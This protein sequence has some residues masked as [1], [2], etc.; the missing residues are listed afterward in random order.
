MID[1]VALPPLRGA[2][3]VSAAQNA[4]LETYGRL[5]KRA[6]LQQTRDESVF[7]NSSDP[8]IFSSDD[9]P[10][11]DD[12]TQGRRKKRYLGSWFQRS[13]TMADDDT[14]LPPRPKRAFT[15]QNADSGI[16]M[17]SDDL[18]SDGIMQDELPL[19][20]PRAVSSPFAP[21]IVSREDSVADRK[22][23]AC[24]D[25]GVE[26][27]DLSSMGLH[28]IS[29]EA[30]KPLAEFSTT[31]PLVTKGVPF[32][33]KD[34]E[35]E[36]YLSSNS[37]RALPR[38]MFDVSYLTTLSL[39]NNKLREL[40]PAIGQLRSLRDL[41]IAQNSL[42]FLPAELLDLVADIRTTRLLHL[43]VHPNPFLQPHMEE[44]PE[45]G[46]EE[47]T[48]DSKP[49]QPGE[50]EAKQQPMV[51]HPAFFWARSPVQL[52]DVYGNIYSHFR[53]ED[54]CSPVPVASDAKVSSC[55]QGQLRS[56]TA[57]PSRVPTLLDVALRT[58]HNSPSLSRLPVFLDDFPRLQTLVTA[59][60]PRREAGEMWCASCNRQ[61]VNPKTR[62]LEWWA[63]T[64]M[65]TRELSPQGG[66]VGPSNTRIWRQTLLNSDPD[67][68]FV[69]FLRQGC[70]WKCLP[71][72]LA[73][74]TWY[75]E[76]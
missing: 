31:I 34:P 4:G 3:P 29:N 14:P 10:S 70:T 12:Y 48:V 50:A 59:L 57:L 22:I 49:L 15:R 45:L 65:Q 9:E 44:E 76:S 19:P 2:T 75:H 20:K 16:Y 1:E 66:G 47:I 39:R 40:P 30:I 68:K 53:L 51:L 6:R 71:K 28:S 13:R 33:P 62:W 41:N 46:F 54:A 72:E 69:P 21:H 24:V 35:I 32:E 43:H 74:G 17:A 73:Q 63:L 55:E 58:C 5:R 23:R 18:D 8:A 56:S 37:L 25:A 60:I 42:R 61:L 11:V 38:A 7:S 67:E 26:R 27:I 52:S 64:K 36:L